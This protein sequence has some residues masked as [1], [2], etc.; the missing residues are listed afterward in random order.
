MLGKLI[1]KGIGKLS[2]IERKEEEEE[3]K[4]LRDGGEKR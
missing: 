1:R 4:R 3:I 2:E